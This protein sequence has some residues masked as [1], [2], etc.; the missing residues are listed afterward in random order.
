MEARWLEE[1]GMAVNPLATDSRLLGVHTFGTAGECREQCLRISAARPEST[2]LPPSLR[3]KMD[4]VQAG[5]GAAA[6]LGVHGEPARGRRHRRG[7]RGVRAVGAGAALRVLE[8]R[9]RLLRHHP[10]ALSA[11]RLHLSHQSPCETQI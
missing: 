6:V 5:R 7:V 11:R 3:S 4:G 1:G 2:L 10:L 8:P 9:L